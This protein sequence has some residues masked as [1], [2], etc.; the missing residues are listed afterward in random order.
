MNKFFKPLLIL[1]VL[2]Q[3]SLTYAKGM[4]KKERVSSFIEEMINDKVS[5]NLKNYLSSNTINIFDLKQGEDKVNTYSPNGYKIIRE[6]GNLVVAEIW[7]KDKNWVHELTFKFEGKK[8]KWFFVVKDKPDEGYV[9]LWYSVKSYINNYG[10]ET[11]QEAVESFCEDM[12]NRNV[13]KKFGQYISSPTLKSK[14]INESEHKINSYSIEGFKITSNSGNTVKAKIWGNDKGWMH[15]LTFKSEKYDGKYYLTTTSP[16]GQGYVDLWSR[17]RTNISDEIKEGTTDINLIYKKD[18]KKGRVEA[19]LADM[20]NKDVNHKVNKYIS[21]K[22]KLRKGI[23]AKDHMINAY[24]IYGFKVISEKGNTVKAHIWG[25]NKSWTKELTFNLFQENDVWYFTSTSPSK[26]NYV[27]LWSS[28]KEADEINANSTKKDRVRDFL[29]DMKNG[30]LRNKLNVY[31]SPSH[32]Y[33][34]GLKEDV[35]KLNNFSIDGFEIIS[36]VGNKIKAEIW[37]TNRSF[38]HE[39]TFVLFLEDGEWYFTGTN[40]SSLDYIDLWTNDRRNINAEPEVGLGTKE[41]LI[42]DFLTEMKDKSISNK[43]KKYIAPSAIQ[44]YGINPDAHKLNSYV[45]IGFQILKKDG[46][47]VYTKVWGSGKLE[48]HLTFTLLKE[49]NRWYMDGNLPSEYNYVTPW[50]KEKSVNR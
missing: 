48:H 47:K 15:E 31:V 3:V 37:G 18:S 50:I 8:N 44:A 22:T 21:P 11:P 35:H 30:T 2:F 32:V 42:K 25:R 14:N 6:E 1:V 26:Y 24:T 13:S 16:S 19:F 43:I 20:Q 39:L 23:N 34:K 27:D 12:K 49:N 10:F 41:A 40:P 36:E 17:A 45:I 33:D 29:T 46:N 9:N 38:T 28:S 7:G 4:S 5:S